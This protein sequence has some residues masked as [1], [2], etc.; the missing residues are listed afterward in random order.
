M[1]L[2]EAR[3]ITL[4]ARIGD[5]SVEVLRN[6]SFTLEAGETLGLVG[7][8]GAGKSMIGRLF[9]QLLPPGFAVSAGELIFDGESLITM[10][11]TRRRRLLG[12]RIAF[13]PQE[14][15]TALN[16]VLSIGSQF[17]EH[18]KRY[19]GITNKATINA[20]I[21]VKISNGLGIV[22]H[23]FAIWNWLTITCP[24]KTRAHTKKYI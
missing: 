11:Q 8:S 14:P 4:S 10:S 19:L 24:C 7:E 22:N 9:S 3:D 6:V 17:N 5:M 20:E 1:S 15:M 2:V 13:V 18:L 21:L 23:Y 16:P 12:K